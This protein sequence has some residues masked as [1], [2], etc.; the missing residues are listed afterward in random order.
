MN[1]EFVE[2]VYGDKVDLG[3][4]LAGPDLNVLIFRGYSSS[5]IW[6]SFPTLTFLTR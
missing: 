1:K 2:K 3:V 5:I 6:R 4:C